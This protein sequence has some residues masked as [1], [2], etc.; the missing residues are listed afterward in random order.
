MDTPSDWMFSSKLKLNH[1]KTEFIIF[2]SK[3]ANVPDDLMLQIGEVCVTPVDQVRNIGVIF[4]RHMT[5]VPQV[6]NVCSSAMMCVRYLGKIR[7]YLSDSAHAL[8]TSKVDTCDSLLAGIPASTLKP[9]KRVLNITA[10]IVSRCPK[11]THITPLLKSLH[12]LPVESRVQFK[13]LLILYKALLGNIPYINELV[14]LYK[15]RYG[16]RSAGEQY[17]KVSKT[18][19]SYGDRSFAAFA[20]KSYNSL[21]RDVRASPSADY[22]KSRLKTH[23][24]AS[25]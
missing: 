20:C 4:D 2:S 1:S 7:P 15:T 9:I 14:Q 13:V 25:L 3:H 16:L 12:W 24:F 11:L 10:R 5:M 17:L 23:L 8:V 6:K 22:F 19:V 21:P 18:R